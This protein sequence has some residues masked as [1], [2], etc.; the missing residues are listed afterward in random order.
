M[1]P[2]AIL[3]LG[4]FHNCISLD[5]LHYAVFKG[6]F[7]VRWKLRKFVNDGSCEF[8]YFFGRVCYALFLHSQSNLINTKNMFHVQFTH[9]YFCI[10]YKTT[11]LPNVVVLIALPTKGPF[12]FFFGFC[13]ATDICHPI[14]SPKP[15]SF[16]NRINLKNVFR[17]CRMLIERGPKNFR[18]N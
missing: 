17:F 4:E 15:I 2:S 6:D 12:V 10:V 8:F 18:L 11:M 14:I 5:I 16:L 1:N 13:S 9:G 3:S 7:F